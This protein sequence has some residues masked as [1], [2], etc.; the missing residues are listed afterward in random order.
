MLKLLLFACLVAA[1]AG[2]ALHGAGLR[3]RAVL[4]AAPLGLGAFASPLRA[5]ADETKTSPSGLKYID[6]QEGDGAVPLAGQTVSVHYTGWLDGFDSEKKFGVH[7][8]RCTLHLPAPPARIGA[9]LTSSPYISLSHTDSSYDRRKPLS[10]AVGTGRVIK[11]W[12]E[13]LLS[14]KVG[15]KR[16]LVIPAELGYGSK[17][18]GG[19]IPPGATLYFDVEL[20]KIL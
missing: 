16:R 20:L 5:Q 13:G 8:P 19:I 2:L 4:A 17:G 9:A 14:M 1:A 11:G 15:G 12:D 6:L 10:F 7:S 3:R 18:A